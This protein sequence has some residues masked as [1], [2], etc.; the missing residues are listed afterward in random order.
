M[1]SSDT[2]IIIGKII[3]TH[4]IKGLAKIISFSA[5]PEQIFDYKLFIKQNTLM[6]FHPINHKL[7]SITSN[8][9]LDS[10]NKLNLDIG[11]AKG[12]STPSIDITLTQ[13]HINKKFKL[14]NNIFVGH[15]ENIDT[16]EACK[17]FQGF[18]IYIQTNNL[19]QLQTD[20]FY[21]FQLSNVP[22][23]IDNK[24]IGKVQNVIEHKDIKKTYLEVSLIGESIVHLA[25]FNQYNFPKHT[26]DSNGKVQLEINPQT[27]KYLSNII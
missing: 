9:I 18:E 1:T 22:V 13:L 7:E 16:I 20:E 15:I 19:P 2:H 21:D 17:T 14:K 26:F 10:L 5:Q 8:N 27:L 23:F 12:Q 3:G 4:G 24:L 6:P 25:E 11:S